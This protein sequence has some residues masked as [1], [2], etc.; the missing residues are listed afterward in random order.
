M[1]G[2]DLESSIIS[3]MNRLEVA[4]VALDSTAD[5]LARK[6][7]ESEAAVLYGT[8][9]CIADVIRSLERSILA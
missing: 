7:D 2:G 3:A 9:A 4:R 1:S 5:A 6:L 8:A